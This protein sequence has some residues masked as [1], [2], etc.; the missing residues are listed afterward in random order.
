MYRSFVNFIRLLIEKRDLIASMVKREVATQYVGSFMGF[1]WNFVHPMVLV[2]VLWVVF[3]FGFRVK[4]IE[5]APFVVWLSAGMCGWFV[6]SDILSGS[7]NSVVANATLIK[8]T[9]F[10][11]QIL[12]VVKVASAFIAHSVFILVL[13]GLILLNRLSPDVYYLQFLYYLFCLSVLGIGLGWAVSALNV[14]I[15]D[16]GQI[17][18]VVLQIGFWA[19][20]ILWN[21]DLM[22][23][24]IQFLF[25]LNPMFYIIQGYRE[26][27]I[28]FVPFWQHP[29]Q[30]FYFW[31][32]A[33]FFFIVGALIFQKLKPQFPDVL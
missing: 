4:P 24:R 9:L 33:I 28:Y 30:T 20:P 29:L 1:L 31:V 12:P 32:V 6:F 21:I 19:T 5:D 16:V 15:R 11:S 10:P 14:F 2:I 8:K 13:L 18:R 23:G 22:P 25:K 27:F 26:S 7:A 3:G 17:V